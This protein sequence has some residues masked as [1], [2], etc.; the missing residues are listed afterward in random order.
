MSVCTS[1]DHRRYIASREVRSFGWAGSSVRRPRSMI[2]GRLVVSRGVA[3]P[4]FYRYNW[5]ERQVY[6]SAYHIA[7]DHVADYVAG[8]H[9][10]RPRLL[11]GYAYAHYLLARM[12]TEQGVTLEYAPEAAVLGSEN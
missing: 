1:N 5:A 3:Q 2:G 12:M 8:F 7:P 6:F 11:T 10:H 4:P 9:K